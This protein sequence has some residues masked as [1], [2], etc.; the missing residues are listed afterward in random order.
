MSITH[1]H[2]VS[3]S[4][5]LIDVASAEQTAVSHS[6]LMN[7]INFDDVDDIEHAER[8]LLATALSTHPNQQTLNH[9]LVSVQI[10]I[11]AFL[12]T[13]S[14]SCSCVYDFYKIIYEMYSLGYTEWRK[15]TGPAYLI[16]NIMKTS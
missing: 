5:A 8:Y 3:V 14:V 4:L 1:C 11:C 15:K 13:K 2:H 16:A 12:A 7:I 10:A 6:A 9:L